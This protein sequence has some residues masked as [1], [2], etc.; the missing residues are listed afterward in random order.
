MDV[1]QASA[2]NDVIL[3]GV[4]PYGGPPA[5]IHV[6][7]GVVTA[8]IP[9]E[10]GA[11]RQS[12]QHEVPPRPTAV[13]RSEFKGMVVLPGFV[14]IHTHLREPGSEEAETIA[15][16]SLAAACGGYTDV[17][18]MA[19]TDPVTDNVDRVSHIREL[20][21]RDAAIR[22]HPVGAITLGLE[23][24]HLADF[25]ALAAAG[26]T[27]FSD[28][29]HCVADSGLMHR[30]LASGERLGV[31]VAQ[32]AQDPLLAGAGQVNAGDAARLTGLAEWPAAAEADIIARDVI[33]AEAT[34]GRLHVCHV[35]TAQAVG[36]IRWAKSR[37]FPV[38]AEAAPHHLVLT[39]QLVLGRDPNFKVNPP[40]RT[41]ADVTAVREALYEGVIDCV[42]T[43][44]APHTRQ[45]KAL[46]WPQAPF[47]MIGLE[48]AL[49][50]LLQALSPW[51]AINWYQVADLMSHRPA[52]IG[53]ISHA[54][55]RPIAVG[56]PASL[57]FVDPD[58]TW[59]FN[60]TSIR[61]KSQNS[62]YMGATFRGMPMATLLDG[63]DV[64]N[65]A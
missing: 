32:H 34:G 2:N 29:G 33:L 37:G 49:A 42:A 1:L 31:T 25:D 23:G 28:D 30:A 18:A 57:V 55:G 24:T 44:H 47:G 9:H 26:V 20:A 36:V 15:T 4:R 60:S 63:R 8:I 3:S 48:S 5:D 12:G 7:Q 53:G 50:V 19:N 61:S 6:K 62:P 35:S 45:R 58:A 59:T 54:A 51:G 27:L 41:N 10:G 17:F 52:S 46:D 22:V 65:Y 16:G 21:K 64:W 40:L 43:D 39:D 38:T 13:L 14:D 56:E 11:E